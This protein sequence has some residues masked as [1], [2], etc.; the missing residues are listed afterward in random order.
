MGAVEFAALNR[1]TGMTCI[2]G[3]GRMR[4][5]SCY[6]SSV[7]SCG[8]LRAVGSRIIPGLCIDGECGRNKWSLSFNYSCGDLVLVI[9][10]VAEIRV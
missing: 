9:G 6:V 5:L 1:D 4:R 2:A 7:W 3:D 10:V 8:F